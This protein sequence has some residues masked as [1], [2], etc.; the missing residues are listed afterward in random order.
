[1]KS[2]VAMRDVHLETTE[3]RIAGRRVCQLGIPTVV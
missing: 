1:M 3:S 2:A